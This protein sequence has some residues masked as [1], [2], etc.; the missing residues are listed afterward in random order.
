LVIAKTAEP[1]SDE[2]LFMGIS[3]STQLYPVLL[4]PKRRVAGRQLLTLKQGLGAGGV[5]LYLPRAIK[6]PSLA[7]GCPGVVVI[8]DL[9]VMD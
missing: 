5:S 7:T 9:F 8:T 6:V 3:S 1:L 2:R 4:T